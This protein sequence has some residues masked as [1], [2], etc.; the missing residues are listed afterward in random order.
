MT[1]KKQAKLDERAHH[2]AMKVPCREIPTLK[3]FVVEPS[4]VE[5]VPHDGMCDLANPVCRMYIDRLIAN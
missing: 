2:R 5:H 3:L 1:Y 4:I